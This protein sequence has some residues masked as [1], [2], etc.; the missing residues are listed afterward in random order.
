MIQVHH[1]SPHPSTIL[2]C[3]IANCAIASSLWFIAI[4]I[5]VASNFYIIESF[6]LDMTHKA[7]R[8]N[9]F[10]APHSPQPA[11]VPFQANHQG[12]YG[13]R[14]YCA[15][16]KSRNQ[17]ETRLRSLLCSCCPP[18]NKHADN[19]GYYGNQHPADHIEQGGEPTQGV[20]AVI[21]RINI[22]FASPSTQRSAL[23]YSPSADSRALVISLRVFRRGF[24][25]PR[26]L[27]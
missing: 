3:S 17:S 19:N 26:I 22:H 25:S 16:R 21:L 24:C 9:E 12:N 27:R 20:F 10:S 18:F 14:F 5:D 8:L 15:T 6:N 13:Y 4:S 2:S 11:A 7:L 1:F 23:A